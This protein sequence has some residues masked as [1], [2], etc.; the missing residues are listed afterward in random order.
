MNTTIVR[1]CALLTLSLLAP[2]FAGCD[3][4][5]AGTVSGTAAV[6]QRGHGLQLG[7]FININGLYEDNTCIDPSG[8]GV[9]RA[10][11]STWAAALGMNASPRPEV[12][13]NDRSCKLDITSLEL[14]DSL[15]ATQLAMPTAPLALGSAFL[16]TPVRFSYTDSGTSKVLEFYANAKIDPADFSNNFGISV[17]YS[18]SPEEVTSPSLNSQYATIGSNSVVNGNVPQPNDTLSFSAV[19][20]SRDA[21]NQIASVSGDPTLMLGSVPGQNYVIA[22]G[23]CPSGLA[24]VNAAYSSGTQIPVATALTSADFG[25]T[26]G[27]DLSTPLAACLITANCEMASSI[28]AYQL[29]SITFN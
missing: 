15:G 29:F 6:S 4:N 12:V 23:S 25:L 18:D 19:S 24:A 21:M 22:T 26:V 13:L 7:T 28:C 20:Y 9:K 16:G 17:M 5:S 10:L 14:Q 3:Q 11:S 1:T 8:N 27:H 2:Q